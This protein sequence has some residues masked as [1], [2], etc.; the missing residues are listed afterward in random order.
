MNCEMRNEEKTKMDEWQLW[1]HF[2]DRTETLLK[3]KGKKEQALLTDTKKLKTLSMRNV[4][5][6]IFSIIEYTQHSTRYTNTDRRHDED[7]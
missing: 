4:L 5:E 6:N 7:R 1:S 3:A 2:V